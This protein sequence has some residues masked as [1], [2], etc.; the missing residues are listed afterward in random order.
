MLAINT[1]FLFLLHH[2][3]LETLKGGC[4]NQTSNII[5]EE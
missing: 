5:I 1:N 4:N 3:C 2:S